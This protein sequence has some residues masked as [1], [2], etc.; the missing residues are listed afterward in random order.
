MSVRFSS[1]DLLIRI[2]RDVRRR[3]R[4]PRAFNGAALTL[5]IGFF[6]LAAFAVYVGTRTGIPSQTTLITGR[7]LVLA[8]VVTAFL[9]FV[10]RPLLN[11]VTDERVA[12][13]IEEH[14]PSLKA[15]LLAAVEVSKG[16]L[17]EVSPALLDK[18]VQDAVEKCNAVELQYNI[19]RFRLARSGAA[20]GTAALAVTLLFIMAPTAIRQGA[21]HMLSGG[22]ASASPAFSI[23]VTPG[24]DTVPKGADVTVKATL[25]GFDAED[26]QVQVKQGPAVEFQHW[27]MTRTERGKF[28]FVLFDLTQPAEYKVM[29]EGVE[30]KTYR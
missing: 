19:E 29:S 4:M 15:S 6:A 11:R 28:E 14:E 21:S 17:G 25:N 26:V 8:S 18:L 1:H 10:L 13:Y 30:S 7:L 9:W 20:L 24:N 27:P 5:A 3:W 2:I 23:D 16:E 22:L 12:L